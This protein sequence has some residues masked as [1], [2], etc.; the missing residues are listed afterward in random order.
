MSSKKSYELEDAVVERIEF[1]YKTKIGS[2]G[3]SKLVR[4][5]Q[6]MSKFDG[7]IRTNENASIA[8]RQLTLEDLTMRVRYREGDTIEVDCSCD[9]NY[10]L[11]AMDRVGASIRV[12]YHWVP[13]PKSV[14][15]LWITLED[16]GQKRQS[17]NTLECWKKSTTLRRYFKYPD[18][19]IL[20]Y[21]ISGYGVHFRQKWKNNILA[22]DVK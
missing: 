3:N 6:P 11:R 19:H 14:I 15:S 1:T 16:M 13:P 5:D 20:M 10:M 7:I 9:S 22:N 17:R 4:I 12:A 21:W 2:K 18:L 8:G